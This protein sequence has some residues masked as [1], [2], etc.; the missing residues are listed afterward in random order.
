MSQQFSHANSAKTKHSKQRTSATTIQFSRDTAA[1]KKINRKNKKSATRETSIHPPNRLILT[2]TTTN[3]WQLDSMTQ[4]AD[5]NS[6]KPS[7]P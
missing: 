7:R 1:T 3:E 4:N 6:A 2:E 5:I